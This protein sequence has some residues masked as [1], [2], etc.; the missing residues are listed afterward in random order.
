MSVHNHIWLKIVIS[1]TLSRHFSNFIFF[2][3][4][5]SRSLIYF[6]ING[7]VYVWSCPIVFL[8]LG[9]MFPDREWGNETKTLWLIAHTHSHTGKKQKE[10][11]LIYT[12]AAN[13]VT[14]TGKSHVEILFFH[15]LG[16]IFS[17]KVLSG[18]GYSSPWQLLWECI[19]GCLPI[20]NKF[21]TWIR[22]SEVCFV[23]R[24]DPDVQV[25]D[26]W[27]SSGR[28]W[29][30]SF[31]SSIR[32]ISIRFVNPLWL[33]NKFM[34]AFGNES[35][36]SVYDEGNKTNIKAIT[37]YNTLLFSPCWFNKEKFS[38]V[39]NIYLFESWQQQKL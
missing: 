18:R 2:R 6:P 5:T 37:A 29:K 28:S 8:R 32:Q 39:G 4:F 11:L 35:R 26:E 10:K 23:I 36:Q 22:R 24:V 16:E 30:S 17:S 1:N 27:R 25:F 20:F 13:A 33:S 12:T 7:L 21:V 34:H 38:P 31:S 3:L 15:L 19:Q 9:Q 14:V